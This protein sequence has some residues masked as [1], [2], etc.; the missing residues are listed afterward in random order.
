MSVDACS[1]RGILVLLTYAMAEFYVGRKR[2][3]G[4]NSILGLFGVMALLAFV[5]VALSW[6][7]FKERLS[8]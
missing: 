5:F 7:Q 2:P 1:F 6:I 4:A 8:K 3:M